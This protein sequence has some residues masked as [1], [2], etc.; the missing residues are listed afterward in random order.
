[1]DYKDVIGSSANKHLK[2]RQLKIDAINLKNSFDETTM[3]S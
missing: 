1:M 2:E 3:A